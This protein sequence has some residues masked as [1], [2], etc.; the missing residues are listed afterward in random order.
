[1]IKI[2]KHIYIH[3]LTVVLFASA[4]I[5]RT[6]GIT[7]MMYS[8]MLLHEMAHA[9][10]ALYLRIG[11]SRIILYPFGVSLTVGTRMLCTFA[12]S[13]ILYLA[14]PLV[15]ALIAVFM[16]LSGVRNFFFINNL[17]VFVL[18][19][20]PIL[21]LDGGRIAEALLLRIIG[22][23]G[24]R[25]VMA[26]VSTL[27]A[28]AIAFVIILSGSFNVNSLT[29]LAFILGGCVMQKPKYNRDFVREI[30]TVKEKSDTAKVLL[31]DKNTPL[32][33][34]AGRFSPGRR[35]LVFLCNDSGRV[36]CVKTDEEVIFDI[37][38]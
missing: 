4:Y 8:V 1:M 30:A 14:G 29:F 23:R 31:V 20:M 2:S 11:I 25:I 17:V 27:L 19:M 36:E 18:N 28:V 22:E 10:A 12:D 6:L 13:L 3:W 35:T 21:P 5:T 15:N 38:Q 24:S 37:L 33:K 34:I 26:S 16:L 7:A 32:R 9:S